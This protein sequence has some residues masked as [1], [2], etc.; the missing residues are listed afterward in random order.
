MK[1]QGNTQQVKE[2]D[3]CPPNQTK[4][5]EIGN[6]PEKEFLIMIVKMIQNLENKM[7]LQINSLEIRIEKMQEKFNKDIE[8]IKKSQ[9]IMNNAI[10]ET[11]ALWSEPTVE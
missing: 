1:R 8:E 7:E 3:K 11:K 4:E 9:S 6:L 5:E 10:T 2:Q